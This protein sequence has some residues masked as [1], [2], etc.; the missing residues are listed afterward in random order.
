MGKYI[1]KVCEKEFE[2]KTQLAGHSNSHTRTKKR[3]AYEEN[4]KIC[5]ECSKPIKWESYIT[6]HSI[7]FCSVSC[8]A[9]YF[10]KNNSTN[11]SK[12]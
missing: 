9:H 10:Y 12:I 6:K 7:E 1:C 3:I 11:T 5:K 2:L 8:R 4:P